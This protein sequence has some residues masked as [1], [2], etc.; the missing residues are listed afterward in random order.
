MA[1]GLFDLSG[2]RA[3]VTGGGRGLGR[4]MAEA[5]VGAGATV[6]LVGR[7][8]DVEDAASELGG[9]AVRADL[10]DAAQVPVAFERAVELLGG[11]DILVT[12]HGTTRRGPA[13]EADAASWDA[14]LATNLT[15]VF[16]LCRL[17]GRPMVAAGRG[18]IVTVASMLSFSGGFEVSSYAASKG[19]VAQLTKA[20]ANEWA[21][22]GVNVNAIAPGYFPTKMTRGILEMIGDDAAK[23][24]P[25]QRIGGPE[26]LKGVV[27]LLASDAGAFITGQIIAVDGGVTAR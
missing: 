17:A 5:L 22:H 19:G 7:S 4:G 1:N 2:R 20:L 18:K 16:A 21:P 25:L 15:S 9:V 11:I 27:A 23:R 3:V 12:A 14:V 13:L 10:A 24:A 26:D 8:T 6:A